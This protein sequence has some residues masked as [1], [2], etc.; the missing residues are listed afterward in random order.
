VDGT[1]VNPGRQP[2]KG[3]KTQKRKPTGLQ[4]RG[5][6]CGL[7]T[8]SHKTIILRKPEAFWTQAIDLKI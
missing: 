1:L 2:S 8:R 7:I 5:L 6:G 3:R 4:V